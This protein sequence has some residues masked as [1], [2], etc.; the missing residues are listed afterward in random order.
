MAVALWP[1]GMQR[2]LAPYFPVPVNTVAD[3][4]VRICCMHLPPADVVRATVPKMNL[5]DVFVEK[6]EIAKV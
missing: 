3:V 4:E 2:A 6:E 1:R 5:D